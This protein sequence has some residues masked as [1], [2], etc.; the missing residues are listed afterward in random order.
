MT[1]LT[2]QS[3]KLK[4]DMRKDYLNGMSLL[5]IASKY[6]FKSIRTVYFHLKDLT[7]EEKV[8]HLQ[9]RLSK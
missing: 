8:Q 5:D 2:D 4:K 6:S 7:K 9:R 1:K 3:V